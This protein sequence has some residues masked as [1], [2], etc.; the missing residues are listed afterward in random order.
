MAP[1]HSQQGRHEQPDHQAGG[2]AGVGQVGEIGADGGGGS[3]PPA[4]G[5][6]EDEGSKGARRIASSVP[7]WIG[8]T[9]RQQ[10]GDR[11]RDHGGIGDIKNLSG[12]S[13]AS[14]SP[15]RR[16][17]VRRLI[18]KGGCLLRSDDTEVPFGVAS[19]SQPAG[20]NFHAAAPSRAERLTSPAREPVHFQCLQGHR[21]VPEQPAQGASLRVAR[22]ATGARRARRRGGPGQLLG[23]GFRRLPEPLD[24]HPIAVSAAWCP[25]DDPIRSGIL[26]PEFDGGGPGPTQTVMLKSRSWSFE[27]PP[28]HSMASSAAVAAA[29]PSGRDHRAR[30]E[31]G[32]AAFA[33]VRAAPAR[34]GRFRILGWSSPRSAIRPGSVSSGTCGIPCRSPRR[35]SAANRKVRRG[36]CRRPGRGGRAGPGRPRGRTRRRART[37]HSGG[38]G[39]VKVAHHNGTTRR[40]IC[41]P[42]RPRTSAA[43]LRTWSSS[44]SRRRSAPRG[45]RGPRIRVAAIP[46]A[47]R[48]AGDNSSWR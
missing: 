3:S 23:R 48:G 21:A 4:H 34:G 8:S 10:P 46:V 32:T 43:L 39:R 38:A 28:G 45:R 35:P 37:I 2:L 17:R 9:H 20:S 47:V 31:R 36:K 27:S 24:V 22:V 16:V 1:S 26:D 40:A 18:D 44:S 41:W 14:R 29:A 13:A 19:G 12:R 25:S 33:R 7:R 42:S 30:R 15:G 11:P 6:L 5:N